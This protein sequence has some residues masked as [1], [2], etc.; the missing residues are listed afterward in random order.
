MP[1]EASASEVARAA[2]EAGYPV[3]PQRVRQIRADAGD[4][5]RPTNR[6]R[7]GSDRSLQAIGARATDLA[8]LAS[9]TPDELLDAGYEACTTREQR[10]TLASDDPD[11]G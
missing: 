4:P 8:G 3:S 2:A 11:P 1:A 7:K 6:P 5:P 10:A 9:V